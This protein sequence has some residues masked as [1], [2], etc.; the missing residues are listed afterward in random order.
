MKL[1]IKIIKPFHLIL[2]QCCLFTNALA[3]TDAEE[4]WLNSDTDIST[5]H[6][7]EG[8]LHFLKKKDSDIFFSDNILTINNKSI[9]DGWVKLNQC[10]ANLDKL[11]EVEI[12]YQYRFIKDLRIVSKQNIGKAIPHQQSI[13]LINIEENA[14]ICVTAN[15][16]IFYQNP[17]ESFSLVNGPYHRRFLDGFYPYHVRLQ[18]NYPSSALKYIK[19]TPANQTGFDLRQNNGQIIIDTYFEGI[20]NTEINFIQIN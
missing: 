4:R 19:S 18:I 14:K 12:S 17:D 10:F 11:P 7:N 8:Q 13:T 3:F 20:L 6:V 9:D 2:L 16:R 15:V 1:L 5:E